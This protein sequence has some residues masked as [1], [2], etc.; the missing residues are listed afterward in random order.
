M[1]PTHHATVQ[2]EAVDARGTH[3][4]LSQLLHASPHGRSAATPTS[5]TLASA[6]TQLLLHTGR[7]GERELVALAYAP[8]CKAS[9]QWQHE[10]TYV[11]GGGTG[12][13][14]GAVVST[15]VAT[16]AAALQY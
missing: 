1:K 2:N 13:Q 11:K 16:K 8:P 4:L 12:S 5:H 7:S 10:R 6:N 15:R 3:I 14:D 9:E